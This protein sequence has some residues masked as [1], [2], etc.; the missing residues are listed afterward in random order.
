M[1]FYNN[2][3]LTN[4]SNRSKLAVPSESIGLHKDYRGVGL[5]FRVGINPVSEKRHTRVD[6]SEIW[7]RT[8]FQT[9]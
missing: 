4:K 2:I 6:A 8:T 3:I 1:L 9:K 7:I 5:V